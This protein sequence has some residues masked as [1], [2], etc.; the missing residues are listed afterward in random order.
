V[1]GVL[2]SKARPSSNLPKKGLLL[3]GRPRDELKTKWT[4]NGGDGYKHEHERRHFILEADK[5]D[6]LSVRSRSSPLKFKVIDCLE[7]CI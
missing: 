6:R 3:L 4:T 5:R 1:T 7:C 2:A